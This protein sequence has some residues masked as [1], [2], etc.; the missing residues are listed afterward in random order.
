MNRILF[1]TLA[2]GLLGCG[3]KVDEL[4]PYI[5]K[6]KMLEKYGA[7]LLKYEGYLTN[8]ETIEKGKDLKTLIDAFHKDVFSMPIPENKH[9]KAV[10]N[11]L[12]RSLDESKKK[13]KDPDS[14]T[15]VVSARKR[16]TNVKEAALKLC[17]NL[18]KIWEEE[19][20]GEFP[21]K[22]PYSA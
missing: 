17:N 11:S 3:D 12:R 7:E 18:K 6:M 4:G 20:R 13:L 21:I 14:L 5:L 10:H 8:E 9:L 16:I 2:L 19:G 22:M 15:F 1:F